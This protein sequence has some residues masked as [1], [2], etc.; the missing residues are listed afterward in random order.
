MGFCPFAHI[1]DQVPNCPPINI[2]ESGTPAVNIR[3][4]EKNYFFSISDNGVGFDPLYKDKLFIFEQGEDGILLG[5]AIA[6][7][8]FDWPPAPAPSPVPPDELDTIII[9]LEKH[10]MAVDRPALIEVYHKGLTLARAEQ[11]L[12]HNQSRYA[13]Y[14][15]KINQPD[16][17]KNQALF[18]AFMLD[19]QK[20]INTNH[21]ATYASHGDIT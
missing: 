17:R 5:E 6:K 18:N 10:N 20:S 21:V 4:D 1:L 12:Q 19:C 13:D 3:E 16:D 7:K 2:K 14:M 15:K 11:V 8:P 9:L